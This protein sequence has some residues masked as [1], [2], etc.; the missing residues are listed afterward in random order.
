MTIAQTFLAELRYEVTATRKTLAAV[1]FDKADFKPH[2]K[3][4]SLLNLAKHVAE[5]PGWW[6]ET[7]LKDELDFAKGEHKP[8]VFNSTEDLLAMFDQLIANAEK[9]LQEVKDEEF[10]KMWTMRSGET[11]FFTLPKAV[12]ARTWCLNHWYH[13]RAQLGVYLRLLNVPVPG[14]YGPSADGQ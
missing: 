9:I 12:V 10:H 14:V 13:H 8:Q 7:L 6:K 3:S 1:P 4:M 11:V 5:I 2:E